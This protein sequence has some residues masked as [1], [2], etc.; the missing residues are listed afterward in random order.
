MGMASIAGGV[1]GLGNIHCSATITLALIT[2]HEAFTLLGKDIMD[3]RLARLEV[4]RNLVGFI[5]IGTLF[6]DGGHG[7]ISQ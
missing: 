4:I 3:K 1:F 2:R 5:L 7:D 6:K